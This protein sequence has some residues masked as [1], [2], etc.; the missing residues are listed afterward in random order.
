MRNPTYPNRNKAHKM[1][2]GGL[3]RVTQFLRDFASVLKDQ[4]QYRDEGS[5][6]LLSPEMTW[7]DLYVLLCIASALFFLR[8]TLETTVFHRVFT[9]YR[10]RVRRKLGENLFYG[11]YYVLAFSCYFFMVRPNVDW[12]APLFSNENVIVKQ[13]LHPFPPVMTRAE[14]LYYDQA[15]GF[16]LAATTFLLC[17]DQRRSDYAE[18][19]LHHCVTMGLLVMSYMYGYTR[20]GVI[21]IALHD[22]SDILLYFAKFVHYLNM[23]GFDTCIFGVFA[24]TFYVTRMLMYARIVYA[25]TF[26]TLFTVVE[27]PAFNR[28]AMYIDTYII[29]YLFFALLL[30]T[31]LLLQCFWFAL[32]LRM[33][34][35]ELFLGKK[36]SDEGDIRSD[37]EDEDDH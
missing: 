36:I 17:Y 33:I 13:L 25:V 10:G 32:I 30:G 18:L 5:P 4:Q 19:M 16:Y 15:I 29:H 11:V 2:S 6:S 9:N 28:W 3:L 26:E 37:D 1:P 27:N 23:K 20:V 8:R 24:L 34:H 22:V 12:S 35:K 7:D 14:H 21:V 31:L